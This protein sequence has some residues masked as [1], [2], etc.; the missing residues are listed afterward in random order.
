MNAHDPHALEAQMR[1]ILATIRSEGYPRSPLRPQPPAAVPFVTISRQAGA[2]G[3]TLAQ[4]LVDRLNAMEPNAAQ[5]WTCWDR[6]LVEKVAADHHISQRL[7]ERLD[8]AEHTWLDDLFSGFALDERSHAPDEAFIFRRVA[9]TIRA[10]AQIGRVVIVG[11]G[12]VF[13]TRNIPGAVHVR[14]VAPLQHRVEYMARVLAVPE[15]VAAEEVKQTDKLRDAFYRRYWP[16]Q[17]LSPELFTLTINTAHVDESLCAELVLPLV[18]S[19]ARL[20]RSPAS[21]AAGGV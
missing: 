18:L 21:G 7:I 5:P 1:P 14:L 11:R 6:E 15:K 16:G 3:W 17:P 20:Q 9:H 2:G 12:G 19:P 13:F 10:L 8:V 4:R